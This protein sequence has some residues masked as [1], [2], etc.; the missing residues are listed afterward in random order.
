MATTEERQRRILVALDTSAH[1]RAAL[2][3]AAAFAAD[4]EADLLGLFVEDANLLRLAALPFARESGWGPGGDAPMQEQAMARALRAEAEQLRRELAAAAERLHVRWSFR[5]ARGLVYE[6]IRVAAERVDLIVM[7]CAGRNP[8]TGA[9]L[10]ST[11]RR[12]AQAGPCSVAL[13]RP[14]A[15]PGRPVVLVYPA[16][17]TAGSALALA[18]RLTREDGHNLV[19]LVPPDP[20]T[21]AALLPDTVRQQLADQGI[22]ARVGPLARGDADGLAALVREIGGRL[23]VLP[24]GHP[25]AD[26]ESLTRLIARAGCPVVVA[27]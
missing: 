26:E 5:V 3:A 10:G 20:A 17:D 24:A 4:L 8:T 11:A 15:R 23:I 27:R 9:R 22:R 19:V 21:G 2:E 14:G 25:L 12:T 18:A 6:E 13:L 1:G 7:G 16:G